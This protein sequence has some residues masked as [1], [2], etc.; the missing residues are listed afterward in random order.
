[1]IGRCEWGV[2]RTRDILLEGGRGCS[3]H[4]VESQWRRGIAGNYSTQG[5]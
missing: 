3:K 1:M 2:L 4:P 5:S